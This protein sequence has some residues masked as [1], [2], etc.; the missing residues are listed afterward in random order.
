MDQTYRALKVFKIQ[1]NLDLK[2][3]K[4]QFEINIQCMLEAII[5][6]NRLISMF[7]NMILIGPNIHA[8]SMLRILFYPRPRVAQFIA[9]PVLV[10]QHHMWDKWVGL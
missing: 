8:P 2:N 3:Q 6:K 1:N 9:F 10:A 7:N 4:M 5:T